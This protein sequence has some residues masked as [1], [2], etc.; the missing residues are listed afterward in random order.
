MFPTCSNRL[1]AGR[2]A[3]SATDRTTIASSYCRLTRRA[4]RTSGRDLHAPPVHE[5]AHRPP[6][7]L[8][9]PGC[10]ARL[11]HFPAPDGLPL[12]GGRIGRH[13]LEPGAGATLAIAPALGGRAGA[14]EAL[15][16]VV[17]D[18]LELGHAGHVPL[19]PK[20]RMGGLAGL[21]RVRRVGGE[22]SLEA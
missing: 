18:L 12:V 10:A 8:H 20:E 13:L 1:L 17:A 4:S 6:L 9:L 15:D 3:L 11:T 16:Q 7:R 2:N 5:R 19:G 22:L 21:S 14:V